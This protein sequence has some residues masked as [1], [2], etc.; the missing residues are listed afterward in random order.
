MQEQETSLLWI[1]GGLVLIVIF[2][3][4]LYSLSTLIRPSG[5]GRWHVYRFS[6][7]RGMILRRLLV[8][9]GVERSGQIPVYASLFA[10]CGFD[11][12]W[13][14]LYVLTKRAGLFIVFVV[15]AIWFMQGMAIS[16]AGELIA[17]TALGGVFASLWGDKWFWQSFKR[18]R[19]R[20]IV[21]EVYMISTQLMYY[22][23]SKMNVHSKLVRCLPYASILHGEMLQLTQEWYED[24]ATAIQRFKQRLGTE[25]G[26]S[27]A[28]V[29]QSLQQNDS[30][31]YYALLQTRI[32]DYKD[33][34]ELY[35]ASRKEAA[36]YLLF[37]LAGLPILNTFRVFLYP[38][39]AEGQ[40]ILQMLN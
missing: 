1:G 21:A 29:L 18:M 9:S 20:R 33:K 16:S 32:Q 12:K 5:H 25:E 37:V 15:T 26:R 36:S 6:Q 38:W 4:M 19:S 31:R 30:D 13:A 10:S 7:P 34:L 27:F 23:H 28:E 14:G 3:I 40:K 8:W 2:G 39:V 24:A 22:R 11:R 17:L 35:R